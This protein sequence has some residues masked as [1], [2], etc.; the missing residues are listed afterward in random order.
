MQI[1]LCARTDCS[2]PNLSR[3]HAS[4]SSALNMPQSFGM[5]MGFSLSETLPMAD[6]PALSGNASR[7]GASEDP[8]VYL[9]PSSDPEMCWPVRPT[10]RNELD[11]FSVHFYVFFG[12]NISVPPDRAAVFA[13]NLMPVLDSG[14]VLNMEI[15]LNMVRRGPVG[16]ASTPR[17]IRGSVADQWRPA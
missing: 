6:L 1:S 14:G 16:R 9:S 8:V 2:K 17:S 3:D 4:P 5:A 15:K 10:L 7:L 12:P 13:I 11:T